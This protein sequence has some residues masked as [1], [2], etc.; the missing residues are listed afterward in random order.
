MPNQVSA[1]AM[2]AGVLL[3]PLVFAVS[4]A[5]KTSGGPA[6]VPKHKVVI[7][8]SD[9]NAKTHQ[10]ALNNAVN[11]QEAFGVDNVAIEIVAY[12]P[13]LSLMTPKDPASNRIPGL[14]MLG[15]TFSACGNT[16]KNIAKKTGHEVALVK[17]VRVVPAG[18]AR[19]M[20][21]QEQGWSYVRP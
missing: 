4:A 21:L 1:I 12:G 20:E 9:D 8:V 16:M 14:A 3:F 6:F 19:I 2:L 10:L 11:L 17:G 13:G 18:V 5:E 7:Q 15:I